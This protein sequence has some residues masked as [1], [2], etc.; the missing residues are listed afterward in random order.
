VLQALELGHFKIIC[1]LSSFLNSTEKNFSASERECLVIGHALTILKP[2]LLGTNFTIMTDC[3]A[4]TTM[5]EKANFNSGIIKWLL[6]LQQFALGIKYV[7]GSENL[8]DFLSR[9]DMS[10]HENKSL[11]RVLPRPWLMRKAF[12][13]MLSMSLVAS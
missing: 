3:R 12:N 10:D 2:Y 8:S 7:K 6:L 11:T 5:R 13:S 4:L 9:V 1:Y